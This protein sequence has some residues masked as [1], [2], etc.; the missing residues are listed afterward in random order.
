MST[1]EQTPIS[2][3]TS[4]VRNTLGKEQISQDMDRPASD[5]ALRESATKTTIS[6]CQSCP[7]R[8]PSRRRDRIKRLGSR[9]VCSMS[10]SPK[11]RHDRPESP[12]KKDSE[13]KTVFKRLENGV[14]HMLEDKEKKPASKKHH[15]KRASSHRTEALS[16]SK[17]SAGGHWKLRPKK[18]RSSIEDADL[19]QPWVCEKT[20]PF[21]PRICYF[22]LPKR[23]YMPSH[24]KTYDG[25]E[26]LED[27]LK[28]FQA[29]AK[30]KR[31]AMP[32]WCH[33][34]N[35]IL[36]ESAR[37]VTKKGRSYFRHGYNRRPDIS[38]I[39]KK[40][41][42]KISKDR[43]IAE[44]WE[45]VACNQ[46]IKQNSRKGQPKANKKE[47]T[48]IRSSSPYNG[49]IGKPGVGNIQAVPSTAH[50]LLKF[51]VAEGVLTLRSSKIIPI[52]C[53]TVSGPE[54]QPP[55]A[56]Q[57]IEERI[58]PTDMT[59][60][61][62]HV[63]KHRL[64]IRKGYPP[65]RQKRR[66]QA[67]NRNQ[68]I[69]E[70]VEK[71]IDAGIM[72]EIGRWNPSV[73]F[74][75]N[76]FWMHTRVTTK[77]KIAKE[78]K[79]NTLFITSQGVVCYS[80]MHFSL[81]NARATYQR[82][83]DKAFHKQIG[84]NLEVYVDDLVIKIR[85]VDE[86]IRDIEETFK[87][88]KDINMKLNFIIEHPKE[89]DPDTAM[90]VEEELL[91]LWILFTDGSPCANGSGAGLILTNPEGAEFTYALR[92]RFEATNNEAEYEAL[93]LGL[94]IAKEMGVKNLQAN[95]D[96]R[97]VADQVNGTYIAKEV[98]MIRYL[99]K[100]RTLTNGFRMFSI[101]QVPIIVEE[102]E[103]TWMT[104]IYEY[105]TEETLS[106][107]TIRSKIGVKVVY[108]LTR[109]FCKTSA[110]KWVSRKSKSKLRGRNQGKARRKKQ[111]LDGRN[112]PFIPPE[113]GMPTLRTAEVD[114]VQ[115]SKALRIN[116][117]LLEERREHGTIREAKSKEKMEKIL[118]LKGPQYK[119]Q[120]RRP[121]VL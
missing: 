105:L 5:A 97:L 25:I 44:E 94:R 110:S 62:R 92:F 7:K 91:E 55:A 50:G 59:S 96:S 46:R 29:A 54:G 33:M 95:V 76:A 3:P 115:K 43:R 88:L 14:F 104:P 6:F 28:I 1:N 32:T 47:E 49:I 101:K 37:L 24:V 70:E 100:V 85:T 103:N 38:R 36:I 121:C 106:V 75:L 83:V 9:R 39:S 78:D 68:A 120:A 109:C 90:E 116:L 107:E 69:W 63:A 81:R 77:I 87:T 79:E 18:Q 30:V 10:G 84:R 21:T 117:D 102:E 2:Q 64:N 42:L 86:I 58:K 108:P 80:K 111:E 56:H 11:L 23:T 15:N 119:L 53:A 27:H 41:A 13:R 19:S 35:S 99:E 12:R 31:W 114:M 65:V 45:T 57:A 82:L 72:K 67:G 93:I 16:E 8:S 113:I 60:V 26:D 98:D 48:S 89:D 40:E 71:L 66:S 74:H 34:F 20:Y 51:P 73:D 118:Q 4:A 52:E 17:G 61:S 22:D 112:L